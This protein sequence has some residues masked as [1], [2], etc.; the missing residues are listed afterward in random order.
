M[1]AD[2]SSELDLKTLAIESGYSRNPFLRM[3]REATHHTP[4]AIPYICVQKGLRR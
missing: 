2:L 1:E 4:T 3:F